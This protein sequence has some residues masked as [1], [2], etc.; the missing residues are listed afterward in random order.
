[1]MQLQCFFEDSH[2]CILSIWR[3]GRVT[4]FFIDIFKSAACLQGKPRSEQ[5]QFIS[6]EDGN[7]RGGMPRRPSA[8]CPVGLRSTRGSPGALPSELLHHSPLRKGTA[9]PPLRQGREPGWGVQ[10][11][12]G[13]HGVQVSRPRAGMGALP[14]C[15]PLQRTELAVGAPATFGYECHSADGP[16]FP[17]G[18]IHFSLEFHLILEL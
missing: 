3:E 11:R 6:L 2:F 1:M 8:A 15:R 17:G 4:A 10:P 12:Q 9:W 13:T 16:F 14:C 18:Q 5:F 7:S